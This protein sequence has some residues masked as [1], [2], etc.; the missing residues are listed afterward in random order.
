MPNYRAGQA[1]ADSFMRGFS[2]VDQIHARR[3]QEKR[4]DEQLEEQKRQREFDRTMRAQ[5]NARAASREQDRRTAEQD[6]RDRQAALDESNAA[7][8][9]RGFD[10]LTDEEIA[11][12]AT[13]NPRIQAEID[14]DEAMRERIEAYRTAQGIAQAGLTE[15]VTGTSSE[16]NP[17]VEMADAASE[18]AINL[19]EP[20]VS[21]Q[22]ATLAEV[23]QASPEGDVI[24]EPVGPTTSNRF[25]GALG[26]PTSKPRQQA[27]SD[28]LTVQL[29]GD[30]Y[31]SPE[32]IDKIEDPVEKQAALEST[33]QVIA[34][35]RNK[36]RSPRESQLRPPGQFQEGAGVLADQV[37]EQITTTVAEYDAF[38]NNPRDSS[39]F[40]LAA[41]EPAAASQQYF[42]TRNTVYAQN[43]KLA[44]QVDAQMVPVLNRYEEQLRGEAANYPA[45]STEAR[46]YQQS[47]ANVQKSRAT[48]AKTQ[49]SPVTVAD[50]R[51]GLKLGDTQRVQ[52]VQS[53]AN[54]PSRPRVPYGTRSS[55]ETR[56]AATVAGRV[57]PGQNRLSDKQIEALILLQDEGR[58][59]SATA[60]TVMMTGMWP[61]GKDPSAIKSIT[62]VNGW[63]VAMTEGGGWYMVPELS[64]PTPRKETSSQSDADRNRTFTTD[65][66]D[67]IME[68]A[69]TYSPELAPEYEQ[70]LRG[71]ILDYAPRLRQSHY[72]D[73]EENLMLLGRMLMSAQ[74]A[75]HISKNDGIIFGWG[76]EK[77]REPEELFFNQEMR[78]EY[79]KEY[80]M[81]PVVVPERL[82]QQGLNAE[83]IRSELLT[84]QMLAGVV[85]D[86][87]IN[88]MSE[89]DLVWIAN[90]LFQDASALAGGE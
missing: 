12:W 45:G 90:I 6:R 86:A 87:E 43:P 16:G 11:K 25:G 40:K 23:R 18:S 3:R 47:L 83:A 89:A 60:Q 61:P 19:F 31:Y 53:V 69:K 7:I 71:F 84:S 1:F 58:I 14:K 36:A 62:T 63:A 13:V 44:A 10:D 33:D 75:S 41:S 74:E 78:L 37:N 52:S 30:R 56:A 26:L 34:E 5:E 32:E 51:G 21:L 82:M 2:F 88:K 4:L 39:F 24:P 48:I 54:D 81:R 22:E 77:D 15:S 85:S 73:S 65:K 64:N 35:A 46:R 29:P 76:G 8:A 49:P 70:A 59:D 68:G 50:I 20:A 9:S 42:Q 38:V 72:L 67:K 55:G 27:E 80:D 66:L 79:V 28:Q 57:R 17:G